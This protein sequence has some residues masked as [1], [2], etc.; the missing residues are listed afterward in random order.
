[1]TKPTAPRG[2]VRRALERDLS[3]LRRRARA[4]RQV[5]SIDGRAALVQIAR[6]VADRRDA[7]EATADDVVR[8]LEALGLGKARDVR[9]VDEFGRFLGD[10]D[11]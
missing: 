2:P 1:M 11:E 6:E 5:A 4:Q 8:A 3:A 10:L 9:E 7:G